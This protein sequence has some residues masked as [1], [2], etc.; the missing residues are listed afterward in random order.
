MRTAATLQLAILFI[1]CTEPDLAPRDPP[2]VHKEN[3]AFKTIGAI[4]PPGNAQRITFGNETFPAWLRGLSL[5][6]DN[7]VHLYNQHLKSNQSNHFAVIEVSTGTKDLQHC[8]DAIM[9]LRAEYFYA[10][11]MHDSIVFF[12]S[13]R[14]PIEYVEYMKG[15][16]YYLSGNRLQSRA[17]PG[18][19]CRGRECFQA[20][21]ETVF[22][23]SGTYNLYEQ[24]QQRSIHDM[25]PGDVLIQ[26]GSPGHAMVV[27]D[28]ASDQS[29]GKKYFMLAQGFMPAQDIHIVLNPWNKR[30]PWF[31]V[32]ETQPIVTPDW[33]FKAG[34]L[35]S[36]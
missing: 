7:R 3:T 25:Q 14:T 34:Q 22:A 18:S 8:A 12:S 17:V 16:R 2:V 21:L 10:K 31:E 33:K 15:M 23:F 19:A 24:L 32:N 5:R 30:S 4:P 9:R 26:P 6:K 36:W 29:T 20:Y 35:R 27:V 1:A 13:G 11:N 28:M